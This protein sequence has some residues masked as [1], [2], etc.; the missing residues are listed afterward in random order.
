MSPMSAETFSLEEAARAC[1][2]E[3]SWLHCS[4][5]VVATTFHESRF[6]RE[7]LTLD[8]ALD[9]RTCWHTCACDRFSSGRV[10]RDGG[11]QPIRD[12]HPQQLVLPLTLMACSAGILLAKRP[13]KYRTFQDALRDPHD[14]VAMDGNHRLAALDARRRRGE[15]DPVSEVLVYVC[16]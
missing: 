15:P 11:G 9:L 16:R 8:Q 1:G 4:S 10:E 2:V 5:W 3:V 12:I 6:S 13:G 14:L 7:T